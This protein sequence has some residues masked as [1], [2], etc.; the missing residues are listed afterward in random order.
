MTVTKIAQEVARLLSVRSEKLVLA[1]S[2]TSGLIASTLG[3]IPGISSNFCGS[4][5]VYRA[6]SKKNW[7]GVSQQVITKHT[8]ESH[9]VSERIAIGILKNTPEADW[10][11]GIVGHLGPDAPK[12]KDGMIFLTFVRRT[13][14][15][16]I[17]IK[18][19]VAHKLTCEPRVARQEEATEVALTFFA[20]I[21][22]KKS[23]R[24][25]QDDRRQRAM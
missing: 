18:E 8:T 4:A 7:L 22:N 12:E 9:E 13:K 10:S 6:D 15:G 25:S 3:K 21:L 17:K 5:V 23:Q 11:I 24:E 16:K 2:C 1:E 14:R 19:T 20:R